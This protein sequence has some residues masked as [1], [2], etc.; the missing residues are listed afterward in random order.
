VSLGLANAKSKKQYLPVREEH[1]GDTG[2]P[3]LTAPWNLVVITAEKNP[4]AVLD[5]NGERAVIE[6][7]GSEI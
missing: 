7:E 2:G 5:V 3:A 4:V 6:D 1:L